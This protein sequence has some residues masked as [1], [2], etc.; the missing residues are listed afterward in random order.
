MSVVYIKT[1]AFDLNT[2]CIYQPFTS[3]SDTTRQLHEDGSYEMRRQA[4][5]PRLQNITHTTIIEW[6]KYGQ[7][8]IL[9]RISDHDGRIRVDSHEDTNQP[10]FFYVTLQ[11]SH[12]S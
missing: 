12:V 5:I 2:F 11:V 1:L 7:G 4:T 6:S 10:F 8:G 9:T 3:D